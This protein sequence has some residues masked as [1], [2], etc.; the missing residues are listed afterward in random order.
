[1]LT[2]CDNLE[3]VGGDS[4]SLN[5]THH[6]S[7]LPIIPRL[8]ASTHAHTH[9]PTPAMAAVMGTPGVA[10][11]RLAAAA[12]PVLATGSKLSNAGQ[13]LVSNTGQM[14]V[15]DWS[16]RGQTWPN[17]CSSAVALEC[18]AWTVGGYETVG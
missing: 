3:I 4:L 11:V 6:P 1:M 8:N 5:I 15:R 13:M 18:W 16:N 12:L 17:L 9:T 2:C 10:E 14:L 7:A